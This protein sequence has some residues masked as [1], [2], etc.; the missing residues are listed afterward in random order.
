M[1]WD[2]IIFFFIRVGIQWVAFHMVIQGSKL[3]LPCSFFSSAVPPIQSVA[4]EREF[5][6]A[7][8]YGSGLW[9]AYI[10]SIHIQTLS[11]IESPTSLNCKERWKCLLVMHIGGKENSLVNNELVFATFSGKDFYSQTALSSVFSSTILLVRISLPFHNLS[12]GFN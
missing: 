7:E 2:K 10:I 6:M 9:V 3:L 4:R 12:L 8:V 1:I 5:Y 11:V